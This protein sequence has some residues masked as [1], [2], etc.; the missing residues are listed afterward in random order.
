MEL[1]LHVVEVGHRRHIIVLRGVGIETDKLDTTG[2]ERKIQT[3]AKHRLPYLV[4]RTEE[5]VI[6]NE[7][8]KWF[9]EFFENI[10]PPLK[11]TCGTCIGEV[12]TVDNEV[13]AVV[14][15]DRCHLLLKFRMP[16]MRI[17]DKGHA[18]GIPV[19]EPLFNDCDVLRIEIFFALIMGVVG[20]HVEQPLVATDKEQECA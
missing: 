10:I 2:N 5:I 6:A 15:I 7:H 16:Q 18:Q 9:V 12:A 11:L 14:G 17:A 3:V 19:F 13:D 1:L 4:P 8:D 20:M